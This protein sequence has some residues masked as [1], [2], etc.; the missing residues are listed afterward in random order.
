[1]PIPRSRLTRQ[2]FRPGGAGRRLTEW[3][4]IT[5]TVAT[6]IAANTFSVVGSFTGAALAAIVPATLVRIRGNLVFS[7]D[8]AGSDEDQIGSIG[9]AVIKEPARSAGGA[10]LPDPL[11]DAAAD[12]WLYWSSL[13]N[14]G[15]RASA[16]AGSDNFFLDIDGKAMRKVEDGDALVVMVANHH[17][18]FGMSIAWNMRFLWLLH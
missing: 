5:N 17:A 14:R 12:Y 15:K 4:S 8:Q 3:T 13:V 10:A 16:N 18:T 7:S 6:A 1:M 9:V 2:S 11:Q